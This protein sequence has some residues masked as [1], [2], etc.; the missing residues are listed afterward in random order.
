MEGYEDSIFIMDAR[1]NAFIRHH[2]R[3][4]GG[5]QGRWWEDKI[6]RFRHMVTCVNAADTARELA[7][8]TLMDSTPQ[9]WRETL[10]RKLLTELGETNGH[11]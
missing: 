7:E 11:D 5:E 8:R 10:A 2:R 3:P 9:R 4:F 1:R 6:T